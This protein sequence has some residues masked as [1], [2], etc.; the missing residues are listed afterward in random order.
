MHDR[1]TIWI[2]LV[3]WALRQ[4]RRPN[5][6]NQWS[7]LSMGS[8]VCMLLAGSRCCRMS[9]SET[10]WRPKWYAASFDRLASDL[11]R[12]PFWAIVHRSGIGCGGP[13]PGQSTS[14]FKRNLERTRLWP[15]FICGYKTPIWHPR[16]GSRSFIEGVTADGTTECTNVL[17]ASREGE[18]RFGGKEW[19]WEGKKREKHPI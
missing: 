16:L 10:Q 11:Q 4:S 3:G 8:Y 19:V 1:G 17:K 9:Q 13:I 6:N 15:L 2:S 12:H 7:L 14:W 18:I 5:K